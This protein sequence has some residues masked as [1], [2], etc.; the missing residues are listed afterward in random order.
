[1]EMDVDPFII[2]FY[3]VWIIDPSMTFSGLGLNMF[4]VYEAKLPDE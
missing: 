3:N 4:I 1:M 2:K